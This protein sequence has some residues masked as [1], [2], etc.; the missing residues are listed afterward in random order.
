MDSWEINAFVEN[1]RNSFRKPIN[2]QANSQIV[3]FHKQTYESL[4]KSMNSGGVHEYLG[5][6][7]ISLRQAVNS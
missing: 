4:K 5:K 3:E 6:S 7:I 1:S 2:A